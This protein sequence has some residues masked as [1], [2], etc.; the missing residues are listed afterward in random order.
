MNLVG[1]SYELAKAERE[2][3]LD[4]WSVCFDIPPFGFKPDEVLFRSGDRFLVRE[5][6]RWHFLWRTI[7]EF[8]IIHFN[9]GQTIMPSF[10]VPAGTAT[11]MSRLYTRMVELRDLPLLKLAGKGIAVTFQGDD[12]RQGDFCLRK[13]KITHASEVEPGYYS[14]ETDARKRRRIAEIA[15][16]ADQIYALNPDLIH[17]LPPGAQFLPYSHVDLKCVKPQ[18]NANSNH[19]IPVVLHAP[20]HRGVKGT[21]FVLDAVS[22]LQAEG[23][24]LRFVLVEGLSHHEAAKVYRDCDLLV[25]QLLAGWYGGL[26]VEL[27]ALAKP[28]VCYI[29][30]SDLKFIPPEMRK[31]MPI[32][33][34][35]PT[36]IYEVLKEWLTK[37][38]RELPQLGRRSRA[39]VEKWHDPLKIA[40]RLM[41]DYET[42]LSR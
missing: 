20:S 21:R 3:G 25:D 29:R 2:L 23:V 7:R 28:V 36:T 18:E 14:P 24:R 1:N 22:R 8:D 33:D 15:R 19:D 9:F 31:E 13:F 37:R 42:I 27:M 26:A 17:V 32:I 12:A 40:A 10:A 34:A 11:A 41:K 39:Y 38:R 16:Y 30:E 6:K 35:A 4:S 5:G